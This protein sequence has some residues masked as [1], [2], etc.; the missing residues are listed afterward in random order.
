MIATPPAPLSASDATMVAAGNMFSQTAKPA[1]SQWVSC[2][3]VILPASS[4]LLMRWRFK[5]VLYGVGV[6][7]PTHVPRSKARSFR[8]APVSKGC[9]QVSGRVFRDEV[10]PCGA[11]RYRGLAKNCP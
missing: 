1:V 11:M 10:S 8:R 7:E 2:K 5:N 9:Q 3:R 6:Y 4:H